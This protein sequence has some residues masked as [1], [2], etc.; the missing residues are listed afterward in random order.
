MTS[1]LRLDQIVECADQLPTGIEQG[2][3]EDRRPI[4]RGMGKVDPWALEHDP[5]LAGL[6]AAHRTINAALGLRPIGEGK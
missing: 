5:M 4:L 6:E 3:T 2:G 1:P